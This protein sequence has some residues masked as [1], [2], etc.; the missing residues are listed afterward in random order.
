[1]EDEEQAKW[2]TDKGQIRELEACWQRSNAKGKGRD[3]VSTPDASKVIFTDEQSQL[4]RK[5]K[6]TGKWN[7]PLSS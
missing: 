4:H 1:M 6:K 2:H 7:G 3:G 5:T